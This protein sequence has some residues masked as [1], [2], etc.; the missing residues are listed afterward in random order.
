MGNLE[1][2]ARLPHFERSTEPG[3]AKYLKTANERQL[4]RIFPNESWRKSASGVKRPS[5]P[6]LADFLKPL[7][8]VYPRSFVVLD[9]K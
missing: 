9:P 3:G 4:T 1:R 7:I 6:F 5:G 2:G 8:R